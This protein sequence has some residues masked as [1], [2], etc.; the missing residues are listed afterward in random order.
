M[1]TRALSIFMAAVC[2]LMTVMLSISISNPSISKNAYAFMRISRQAQLQDDYKGFV[3]NC[4]VE[5]V[6]LR[7]V[8][9]CVKSMPPR[10]LLSSYSDMI[11]LSRYDLQMFSCVIT[12]RLSRF[13]RD[14]LS[15]AFSEV[16]IP[17][18][19]RIRL[20]RSDVILD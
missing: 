12:D 9:G 13:E 15:S 3:Q 16:I 19:A 4:H 5:R 20:I 1:R 14:A 2:I 7:D 10:S 8:E 11:S 17:V 18:Q 6:E